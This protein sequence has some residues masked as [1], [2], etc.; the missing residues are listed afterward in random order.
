M[1]GI[2]AGSD[3][4]SCVSGSAGFSAGGRR[5]RIR[6]GDG[7]AP[8]H[9]TFWSRDDNLVVGGDQLLLSIS[10]NLGVYPSEP[11]ADPV[12]EWI[13]SCDKFRA[14]AQP[15]QLIL[16]GHKVPYTGLPLRLTQ[17]IDNHHNALDRLLDHLSSPRVAGDCFK[18]LFKREIG[19]GEYGLALVEA[20]AHLN[21]LHQTGQATRKLSVNGA[22]LYQA[23]KKP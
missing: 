8:E 4:G 13:A 5:W 23:Q 12:G 15:D 20:V 1:V 9:A 18:P 16:A 14:F 6:C 21:H 17:M 3:P 11:E 10:P 22:W 2:A 19:R 7:H